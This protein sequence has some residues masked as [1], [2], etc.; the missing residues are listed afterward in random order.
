MIPPLEH[1]SACNS[2]NNIKSYLREGIR[3]SS[4]TRW[5]TQPRSTKVERTNQRSFQSKKLNIDSR[6]RRSKSRRLKKPKK[7]RRRQIRQQRRLPRRNKYPTRPVK[8]YHQLTR[9]PAN[10]S[11]KNMRLRWIFKLFRLK[12]QAELTLKNMTI[13]TRKMTMKNKITRQP[14]KVLCMNNQN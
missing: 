5:T 2:G 4:L 8:S 9:N 7:Q 10:R 6:Y 3:E 1:N 11:F 14:A 12:S 13:T